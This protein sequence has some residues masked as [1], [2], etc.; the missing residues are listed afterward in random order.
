MSEHR[1]EYTGLFP[2]GLVI[3][4]ISGGRYIIDTGSPVSFSFSGEDRITINEESFDLVPPFIPKEQADGLTG[5]DIEGFIGMDILSRTGLTLDRKNGW[6]VFDCIPPENGGSKIG[7]SVTSM[8]CMKYIFTGQLGI[9]GNNLNKVILDTGAGISYVAAQYLD[10]KDRTDEKYEDVNP[11]IGEIAGYYY[12]AELWIPENSDA[13]TVKVGEM[14][15]AYTM[16]ADAIISPF[17]FG[18]EY[19]AFD[20]GRGT[21]YLG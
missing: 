17:L 12:S 11:E 14:P 9:N 7:I 20:F 6:I 13:R 19:L 5:M 16:I 4:E 18:S 3:A 2:N 15:F 8:M 10:E 21:L 1:A